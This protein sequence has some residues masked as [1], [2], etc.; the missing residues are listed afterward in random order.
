MLP[1]III[2]IV[3]GSVYGLAGVG[4]VL[5]YK[6]SGIFNFAQGALA[7]VAAYAFYYLNVEVG[8]AWPVA[9]LIS[10]LILG[11]VLGLG[12]EVM[13]RRVARC[14]ASKRARRRGAAN[15]T[16][17]WPGSGSGVANGDRRRA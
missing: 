1:F 8:L 17:R 9:A 6:T 3:T 5:T 7:T 15:P 13:A 2:G 14:A 12:F 16:R 10:V 11:A 4:L